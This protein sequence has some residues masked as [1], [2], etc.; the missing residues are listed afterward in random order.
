ME[1]EVMG[2]RPKRTWREVVEQVSE[3]HKLNT[4]DA[5]VHKMEEVD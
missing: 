3:T 4:K 5:M 2:S 1:Y